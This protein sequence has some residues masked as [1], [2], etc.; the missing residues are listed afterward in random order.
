MK[1]RKVV[2]DK[3]GYITQEMIRDFKAL[4][5]EQVYAYNSPFDD[6]VFEFN[7]E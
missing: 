4:E 5:V 6:K 2:M 3:F 7:C 1:A